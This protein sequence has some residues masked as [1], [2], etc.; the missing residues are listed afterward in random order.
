MNIFEFSEK[1]AKAL[2]ERLGPGFTVIHRD[3]E[4][5][6]GILPMLEI[7]GESEEQFP[8][9]LMEPCY[10]DFLDGNESE[11]LLERIIS[12]IC[13]GLF[14][15][16]CKMLL[17][18]E[19]R[20]A[21]YEYAKNKIAYALFNCVRFIPEK[22]LT[23]PYLDMRKVFYILSTE[24]SGSHFHRFV[25]K[26]DLEKWNISFD[27]LHEQAMINTPKLLPLECTNM[28]DILQ[29]EELES[30]DGAI[31]T[32]LG[33]KLGLYGAAV[34]LYPDLLKSLSEKYEKD[35]LILPLSMEEVIISPD[36]KMIPYFE[37][38]KLMKDMNK[39]IPPDDVLMTHPYLY[40]RET[41]Q[42]KIV[43]KEE[44]R[45]AII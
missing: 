7:V 21:D 18:Q 13:C 26:A 11:E 28:S 23:C 32:V 1:T 19:M 20:V 45:E 37:W 31:F 39:V 10:H 34:M 35:I 40:I 6:E 36:E 3:K 43:G 22:I 41:G 5:A 14:N 29:G 15:N 42:I 8:P 4:D 12:A 38:N 17:S 25:C 33:N 30:D 24:K 16:D 27:T 2:Q 44:N 9:I